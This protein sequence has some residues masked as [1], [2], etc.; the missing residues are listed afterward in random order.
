MA[1]EFKEVD[2][3]DFLT[4]SRESPSHVLMEGHVID[5]GG[6]GKAGVEYKQEVMKLAGWTHH[7]LTSYGAHPD[8]AAEAFNTLR[9]VLKNTED[10]NRIRDELA[11]LK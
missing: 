9:K 8:T 6:G 3:N 4:F 1:K 5:I 10:P 7:A 2:P 11:A